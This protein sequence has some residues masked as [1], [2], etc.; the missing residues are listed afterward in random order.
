M[1]EEA[2]IDAVAVLKLANPGATA[3]EVHDLL[4]KLD[5]WADE[6][7]SRVK[8]ACSKA[9]KRGLTE[10][11]EQCTGAAEAI[12]PEANRFAVVD[13]AALRRE[14]A[15]QVWNDEYVSAER[16]EELRAAS[17]DVRGRDVRTAEDFRQAIWVEEKKNLRK[18][19][20]S[21]QVEEFLKKKNGEARGV[22]DRMSGASEAG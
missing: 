18:D 17:E 15:P 14:Y 3:K 16:A 13:E 12:R 20:T 9:G 7:L 11:Q 19:L 8:K 5:G 10:K 1:D 21:T 4:T 6:S 22:L 2:L